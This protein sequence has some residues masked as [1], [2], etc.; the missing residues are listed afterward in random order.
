MNTLTLIYQSFHKMSRLTSYLKKTNDSLQLS[1]LQI[2]RSVGVLGIALPIVLSVGTIWLSSCPYLK[3]SIS[4]YYYTLMGSSLTGI[5][6]AVGL[7]LY[8][9]KGFDNWDRISTNIAGICALGVAFFPVN[10]KKDCESCLYCNVTT[11]DIQHWRGIIHFGSAGILFFTL[12]CISLFLFTKTDGSKKPT[13]KKQQR[14]VIY[15]FCG[16]IMLIAMM[17]TVALQFG[18]FARSFPIAHSTFWMESIM[19]WAFGFSWLVKGETIF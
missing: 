15:R 11:R 13:K 9:Y 4:E 6:C 16:V 17:L 1:Y 2:R 5:L 7:S 19:L 12:A 8:S 14:N 10:V 3:D 18:P